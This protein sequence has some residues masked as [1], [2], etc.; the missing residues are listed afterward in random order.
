MSRWSC[1]LA[2][3]SSTQKVPRVDQ[4][5]SQSRVRGQ[6]NQQ[7]R[8]RDEFW[9]GTGLV[10]ALNGIAGT[11]KRLPQTIY[12]VYEG[13]WH[14]GSLRRLSATFKALAVPEDVRS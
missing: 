6:A 2:H 5:A 1:R 12:V 7:V 9:S 14:K 3:L 8:R 10:R 11:H 13:R 4:R